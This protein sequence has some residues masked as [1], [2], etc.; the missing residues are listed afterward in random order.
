MAEPESGAEGVLADAHPDDVA[1]PGV[2]SAL[3]E[4]QVEVDA[5]LQDGL[6][7]LQHLLPKTSTRTAMR[8]D[9]AFRELVQVLAR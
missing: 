3:G 4:V 8:R 1:L 2:P 9:A 7:V 5:P 6:E